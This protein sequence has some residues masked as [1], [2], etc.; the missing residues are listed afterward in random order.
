MRGVDR[1]LASRS[2][3]G[4]ANP[5]I[6]NPTSSGGTDDWGF[7]VGSRAVFFGPC[8][9]IA[10]Y[11]FVH[12][13]VCVDSGGSIGSSHFTAYTRANT[14]AG[15]PELWEPP[16]RHRLFF[17]YPRA[18]FLVRLECCVL[19]YSF[20]YLVHT[21]TPHYTQL[22]PFLSSVSTKPQRSTSRNHTP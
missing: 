4:P 8:W 7:L 21:F 3:S 6:N 20:L 9:I 2:P 15:V 12:Y 5:F 16:C 14:G 11:Y 13:L 18:A 17:F 10:I 19:F 22:L 1:R